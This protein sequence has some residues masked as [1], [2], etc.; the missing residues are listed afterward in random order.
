[1]LSQQKESERTKALW[2]YQSAIRWSDY[3]TARG[4]QNNPLENFLYEE[5][6]DIK[7]SSYRAVHQVLSEDGDRFEQTVE[8]RYYRNPS[9]VEKTILDKQVWVY[10]DRGWVLDGELPPFH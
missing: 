6:S 7:V 5:L 1:M 4:L 8:I 3:E 9:I 10:G 2:I